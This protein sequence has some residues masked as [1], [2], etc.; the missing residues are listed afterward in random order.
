MAK[1]SQLKPDRREPRIGRYRVWSSD[2]DLTI[3]SRVHLSSGFIAAAVRMAKSALHVEQEFV[4]NAEKRAHVGREMRAAHFSFVISCIMLTVAFLEAHINELLYDVI[5]EHAIGDVRE[6]LSGDQL[7]R[8]RILADQLLVHRRLNANIP[9]RYQYFLRLVGAQPF[10]R[11]TNLFQ[12]AELLTKVRNQLVHY[13]PESV[14]SYARDS[15]KY[16]DQ[17]IETLLRSANVGTNPFANANSPF[18]PTKCIAFSTCKW[19]IRSAISFSIE[20]RQR[21]GITGGLKRL[22]DQLPEITALSR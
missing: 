3:Y 14:I 8:L 22:Q 5:D 18:F 9:D 7:D 19:A 1:K 6:H 13:T 11:G 15:K 10:E 12:S 17:R 16:R 21:T 4:S 2:P 20:F